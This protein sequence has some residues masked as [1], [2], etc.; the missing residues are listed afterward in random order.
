MG[1][2]EAAVCGLLLTAAFCSRSDAPSSEVPSSDASAAPAGVVV[3]SVRDGWGAPTESVEQVFA[4]AA[5]A[6][7]EQAPGRVQHPISVGPCKLGVNCEDRTPFSSFEGAHFVIR[8]HRWDTMWD[9]YTYELAHELCH[10][11][12]DSAPLRAASAPDATYTAML[13]APNRWFEEALCETASLFTLRR[14][15][16]IWAERP[17]Y[18]NWREYAPSFSA[19][20]NTKLH[21][22]RAQLP[23]STTLA[24]WYETNAA[25]LRDVRTDRPREAIVAN[26]LLPIFERDPTGWEAVSY[27]NVAG[28]SEAESLRRLLAAWHRSVPP[29]LRAFVATVSE[30]FG[31]PL[32]G[33]AP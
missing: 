17:P 2:R 12:A 23:P 30:R 10:V 32:P 6:L 16:H 8:L 1:V 5:G 19:Y 22:P 26:Q 31:Y 3:L 11:L 20:A 14:M 9:A 7:F 4:S 15:D 21:D 28:P 27:L 13:K 25:A 24:A 29:R 18:P 33:G